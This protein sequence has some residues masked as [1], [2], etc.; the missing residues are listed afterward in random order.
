[1]INLLK[2]LVKQEVIS[3]V[4]HM[5]TMLPMKFVTRQIMHIS[6][7][8]LNCHLAK[9]SGLFLKSSQI[10][11]YTASVMARVHYIQS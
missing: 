4:C 2:Q 7:V 3:S 9:F 10:F 6:K 8:L 5:N 11:N 1:M